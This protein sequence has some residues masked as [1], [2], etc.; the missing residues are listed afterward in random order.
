MTGYLLRSALTPDDGP[1]LANNA[2]IRPAPDFNICI[3]TV[4]EALR[5]PAGQALAPALNAR[6]YPTIGKS[7]SSKKP[8]GCSR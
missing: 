2:S 5:L 3:F 7:K 4:L 8:Q 6:G 1:T